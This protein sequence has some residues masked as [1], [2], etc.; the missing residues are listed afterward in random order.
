MS[1][2]LNET[3]FRDNAELRAQLA[4]LLESPVMQQA[5]RIIED[6]ARP[7]KTHGVVPGV[8][9]DTLNSQQ[10]NRII[11]LHRTL[12]SLV[13]LATPNPPPGVLDGGEE[14]EFLHGLPE[15]MQTALREQR[16]QKS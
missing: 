10:L 2:K 15:I 8:H 6:D 3:Q 12:D 1:E 14:E 16:K 11:G 4:K 5:I 9:V 7:R 13:R